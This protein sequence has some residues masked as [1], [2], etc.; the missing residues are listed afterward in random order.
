[1]SKAKANQK[2][3]CLEEHVNLNFNLNS[4]QNAVLLLK[5]TGNRFQKKTSIR[6]FLE[7]LSWSL[8]FTFFNICNLSVWKMNIFSSKST[9]LHIMFINLESNANSI[10]DFI[11]KKTKILFSNSTQFFWT[12][13]HLKL[14]PTFS[15]WL[16]TFYTSRSCFFHNYSRHYCN[17]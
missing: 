15:L 2:G 16:E 4:G 6:I 3:K 8:S 5:R 10:K 17:R 1:M 9:M 14:I 13:Q 7:I 11:K 12:I